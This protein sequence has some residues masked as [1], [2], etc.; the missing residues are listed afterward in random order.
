M[1]TELP[2]STVIAQAGGR[3]IAQLCLR[4]LLTRRALEFYA[5][6][7]KLWAVLRGDAAMRRPQ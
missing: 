5:R 7:G 4:L 3:A 1:T 2:S 6:F